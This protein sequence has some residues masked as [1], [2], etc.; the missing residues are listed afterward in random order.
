[1]S[2]PTSMLFHKLEFFGR[3][4]T[5][6]SHELKNAL[7]TAKELAGLLDDLSQMATEERPVKN[8]RLQSIC[9][10]ML[11]ERFEFSWFCLSRSSGLS[12]ESVR[13][14][15][16]AGCQMVNVGMESA[17][18]TVLMNMN[19]RTRVAEAHRQIEAYHRNGVAVFSNF[20]LGFPGETDRSIG[21]TIDFINSSAINAYFLN[22]FIVGRGTGIDRPKMRKQ[23]RL[24]GEYICW[25]HAT[26]SSL[27]MAGKIAGIVS[28]IDDGILRVGGLDEMQMLMDHGYTVADLRSLAPEIKGLSDWTRGGRIRPRDV[29]NSRKRL[30][31]LANLERNGYTAAELPE[32]FPAGAGYRQ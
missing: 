24:E 28:R 10:M 15:A 12:Q 26:G 30:E 19:K 22:L 31:R 2:E 16:E 9:R 4:T 25:R 5:S 8:E 23:F 17:D 1:M 6:L 21:R 14:M 3:V 32:P 7:A 20:I 11:E 27:E 29:E 18:P 13:L